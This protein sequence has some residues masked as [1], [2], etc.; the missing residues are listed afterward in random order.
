M[1]RATTPNRY[2]NNSAFASDSWIVRRNRIR[3]RSARY[4]SFSIATAGLNT[5]SACSH[6]ILGFRVLGKGRTQYVLIR[7]TASAA[8][9]VFAVNNYRRHALDA[10]L[11]YFRGYLRCLHVM[12]DQLVRSAR[13]LLHKLDGFL[14]CL[15]VHGVQ[16]L[17]RR[18]QFP[19]WPSS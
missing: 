6:D 16:A 4:S 18:K 14:A 17:A 12:N 2:T 15:S 11:L 10:L 5:K 3:L 7:T 19:F 9:C 13:N 8:S 1:W